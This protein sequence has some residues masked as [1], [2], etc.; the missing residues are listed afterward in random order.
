MNAIAR[1]CLP[2]KTRKDVL[3]FRKQVR[4]MQATTES[5][6]RWL[7]LDREESFARVTLLPMTSGGLALSGAFSLLLAV[8]CEYSYIYWPGCS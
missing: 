2:S 8:S 5:V 6:Q 1:S 3:E 7:C 4:K